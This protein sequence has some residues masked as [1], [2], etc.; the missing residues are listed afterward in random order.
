MLRS[1]VTKKIFLFTNPDYNSVRIFGINSNNF[2]Q[3]DPYGKA[4]TM[5]QDDIKTLIIF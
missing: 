4:T 2:D 3:K 1:V 5:W